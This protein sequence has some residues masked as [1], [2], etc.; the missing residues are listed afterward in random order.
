MA[1]ISVGK[2]LIAFFYR[3]PVKCIIA[4]II[5][6]SASMCLRWCFGGIER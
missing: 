4:E 6:T 5:I 2:G 1:E 3:V